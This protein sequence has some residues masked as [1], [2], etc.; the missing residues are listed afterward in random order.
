MGM[1]EEEETGDRRQ[2]T[3]DRRPKMRKGG[4]IA[5]RLLQFGLAALRLAERMPRTPSARH[6]ALQMVRSA[7]ACGANYEEARAAESRPDFIHKISVAAKEAREALYWVNLIERSGWLSADFVQLADET[8]Q[9]AAILG[10]S[11][12]TAKARLA[13]EQ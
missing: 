1:S 4:D 3:G 12:R 2:E 10:A 8:R 5:E 13:Q 9:I 6:V 7:T 11:M